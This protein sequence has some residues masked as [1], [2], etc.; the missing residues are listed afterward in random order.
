MNIQEFVSSKIVDEN[1]YLT[2]EAQIIFN[3]LFTQLQINFSDEGL[4]VPPQSAEN[5]AQLELAD[6]ENGTLLY[7]ETNDLMKVNIAGVFKTVLTS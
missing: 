4:V 1:G 7:D 3:Q 2:Q 5:I 6:A